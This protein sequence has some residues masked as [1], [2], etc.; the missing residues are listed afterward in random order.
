MK[1]ILDPSFRYTPSVSTDL[2][3]TFARIRRMERESQ[4]QV[5]AQAGPVSKVVRIDIPRKVVAASPRAN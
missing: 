3:K 1:S 2:K 5:E 4:A